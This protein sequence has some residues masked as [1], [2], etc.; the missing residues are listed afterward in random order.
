MNS[1]EFTF[2]WIPINVFCSVLVIHP[3]LNLNIPE[4]V[5]CPFS[6]FPFLP[7]LLI[8]SGFLVENIHTFND[9]ICFKKTDFSSTLL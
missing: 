3:A 8:G 1:S 7:V 6:V 2:I 5:I 4:F 9:G